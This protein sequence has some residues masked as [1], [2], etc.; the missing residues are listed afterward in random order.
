MSNI[1]SSWNANAH[2]WIAALDGEELESRKL[3]TNKAIVNAVVAHHP[4]NVMDVGCG[5]GWLC[6]ALQQHGIATMG[7]DGV[8]QLVQ[9]ARMKG[10]GLFEVATF[11]KMIANTNWTTNLYDAVVFNFCLYEKE[12][13]KQLI[14]AALSWVHPGGKLFIQTLHPFAMLK[15]NEPYTDRWKTES[16][17]GLQRTFTHPYSWYYRTMASWLHAVGHAGWKSI[18]IEEPLHPVNGKPASL[19]I[20]ASK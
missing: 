4:S 18:K 11:E 20:V 5:E 2:Q 1:L 10:P 6:R 13:T 7:V 9:N 17:A 19:I 16:W 14:H 3:V 8:A 15:E 12:M